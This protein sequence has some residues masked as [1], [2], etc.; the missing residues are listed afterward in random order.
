MRDITKHAPPAAQSPLYKRLV[1]M[2]AIW[3][4]S[5]L[6]LGLVAAVLR[7]LLKP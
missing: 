2:A 3:V 6:S 1:W 5:V 7:A 4:A